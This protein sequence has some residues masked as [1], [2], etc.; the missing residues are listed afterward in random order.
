MIDEECMDA[1][2]VWKDRPPPRGNR[3]VAHNWSSAVSFFLKISNLKKKKKA[4]GKE[5]ALHGLVLGICLLVVENNK[6]RTLTVC[7]FFLSSLSF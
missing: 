5:E 1:L 3:V 4:N 6:Y 7:I 2:L